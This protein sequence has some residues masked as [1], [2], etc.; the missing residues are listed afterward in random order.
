MSGWGD[1]PWGDEGPTSVES[2]GDVL[3]LNFTSAIEVEVV[4]ASEIL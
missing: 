4:F 2:D 1:E 3:I